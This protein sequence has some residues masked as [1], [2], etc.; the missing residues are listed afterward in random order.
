MKTETQQKL[1]TKLDKTFADNVNKELVS[2]VR[3]S[4]VTQ[5]EAS[6]LLT[7]EQDK[8]NVETGAGKYKV[9]TI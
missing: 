5:Q 6:V 8:L 3:I 1:D 7:I 9:I 4:P 2:D